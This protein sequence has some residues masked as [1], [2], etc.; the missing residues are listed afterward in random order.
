MS[1][2]LDIMKIAPKSD[3]SGTGTVS[4]AWDVREMD[5]PQGKWKKQGLLLN[6]YTLTL[7]A[8]GGALTSG[9]KL[10]ISVSEP[11]TPF[12]VGQKLEF[13]GHLNKYQSKGEDRAE[14]RV[15]KSAWSFLADH[16]DEEP[17]EDPTSDAAAET[18]AE[19]PQA[20][21]EAPKAEQKPATKEE[22]FALKDTRMILMNATTASANIVAAML[23]AGQLPDKHEVITVQDAFTRILAFNTIDLADKIMKG[24]A[25]GVQVQGAVTELTRALENSQAKAEEEGGA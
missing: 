14:I 15:G 13:T 7:T 23:G 20:E 16:G 22:V 25:T 9:D 6:P 5:S 4:T 1:E 21:Q 3:V 2:A 19:A 11:E 12:K 17:V 10:V 8:T 24:D 18:P